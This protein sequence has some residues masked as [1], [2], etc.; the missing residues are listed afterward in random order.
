MKRDELMEYL[1]QKDIGSAIYYPKPIHLF[2]HISKFGYKQRDFPVAEKLSQQVLSLPVR[3]SLSK[4]E[5]ETI[6]KAFE[7]I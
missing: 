6:A 3:P 7:E 4:E 5:I 1:K 2:K